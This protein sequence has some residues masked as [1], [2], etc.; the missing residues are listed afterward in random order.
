MIAPI[1]ARPAAYPK[2]KRE[3]RTTQAKTAWRMAVDEMHQP[4]TLP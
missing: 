2:G 3:G 1:A 4:G